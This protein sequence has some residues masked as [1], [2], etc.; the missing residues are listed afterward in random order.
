MCRV[1]GFC[2]VLLALLCGTAC[3]DTVFSGLATDQV[4][5][6]ITNS[7]DPRAN[8]DFPAWNFLPISVLSQ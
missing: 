2:G 6:R 3:A 8:S 7:I 1:L 5:N 4:V